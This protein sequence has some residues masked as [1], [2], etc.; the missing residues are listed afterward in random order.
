DGWP[1]VFDT[2]APAR[3]RRGQIDVALSHTTGTAGTEEQATIR[4][5]SWQEL[6]LR[7]V[8]RFGQTL[9]LAPCTFGIAPYAPDVEP[10]PGGVG[11]G[12][13]VVK[14][15]AVRGQGRIGFRHAG[16]GERGRCRFRPAAIHATRGQQPIMPEA[17]IG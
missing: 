6:R 4:L 13:N 8:D 17:A 11:T 3:A 16:L 7:R 10:L 5:W 15:A 12:G 1:D 14:P 9:G 2:P